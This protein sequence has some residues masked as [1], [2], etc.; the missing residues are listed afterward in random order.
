MQLFGPGG[1]GGASLSKFVDSI[2]RGALIDDAFRD[3]FGCEPAEMDASIDAYVAS[4]NTIAARRPVGG[5]T[6]L[7]NAALVP[8]SE[9][10]AEAALGRLALGAGDLELAQRRLTRVVELDPRNPLGYELFTALAA[11]FGDGESVMAAS[12]RAIKLGSVDAA[13]Y[14]LR[15]QECF[16]AAGEAGELDSAAAREISALYRRA[17]ELRPNLA[18]AYRSLARLLCSFDEV[19][20]E[21][22]ACLHNGRRFY[23]ADG[24]VTLGL[25]VLAHGRGDRDEALRWLR[26]TL[27]PGS[28]MSSEAREAAQALWDS[29]SRPE[30]AATRRASSGI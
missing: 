4:K 30:I 29:L 1:D 27:R 19:T 24:E 9:L 16:R 2:R 5:E 15:A 22:I 7:E 17:L 18:L 20:P 11:D 28:E 3:A 26:E 10:E 21:D 13:V 12:E 6:N 8:A 25:A 14:F 23:P